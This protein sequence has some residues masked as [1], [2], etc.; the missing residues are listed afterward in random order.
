MLRALGRTPWQDSKWTFAKKI[1]WEPKRGQ[2]EETFMVLVRNVTSK[3]LLKS[4]LWLLH[5][6]KS[7]HDSSPMS[8][9][10]CTYPGPK[11]EVKCQSGVSKC[12]CVCTDLVATASPG[13][14]RLLN[15]RA[16]APSWDRKKQRKHWVYISLMKDWNTVV[17]T[18]GEDEEKQF[19][20]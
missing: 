10:H 13:K 12:M 4:Y 16:K 6:G 19:K 17:S 3:S 9:A 20:M 5:S 1:D 15:T 14:W 2:A 7:K 8:M 18:V 11:C